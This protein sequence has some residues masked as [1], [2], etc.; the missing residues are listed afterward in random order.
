MPPSPHASDRFP[1]FFFVFLFFCFFFSFISFITGTL[2]AVKSLYRTRNDKR[3]K[4]GKR[5]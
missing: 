3:V 5:L 2:D 4:L 1:F